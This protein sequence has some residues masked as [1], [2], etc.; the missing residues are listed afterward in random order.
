MGHPR[1]TLLTGKRAEILRL[2]YSY[3]AYYERL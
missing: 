3:G 1:D 2:L